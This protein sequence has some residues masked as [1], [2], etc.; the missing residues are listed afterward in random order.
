[1]K[2]A[3]PLLILFFGVFYSLN[4]MAQITVVEPGYEIINTFSLPANLTS[5]LG[6]MMFSGDG[7]M[8]Y[9][10]D[11]VESSDSALW[12]ASVVRNGS[13]D[14]TGFG[15]FSQV[16]AY[17]GM[18]TGLEFGPGT[19][20]YFFR[21]ESG[22]IGQRLTSGTVETTAVTPYDDV[23]GGLAFIPASYPNGGN[24]VT[25]SYDDGTLYL[26]AVTPD[27]DG[28]FTVNEA[29]T[30]Y[31]DF[32]ASIGTSVLGDLVF[33]SSGPLAGNVLM[34]LYSTTPNTLAYFP[35][36]ADGLPSG[37][38]TPTPEVFATG[39]NVTWGVAIDPVTDNIWAI[40]YGE[41]EGVALT[42]IGE[43]A[44]PTYTVGGSI[45]GLTGSVTLQNNGSDDLTASADGSFTFGTS[46]ADGAAYAVT[47]S[48]Q[49]IGQACNVT[50]GS[51]TIAAADVTNVGVV[52]VDDAVLPV[53]PVP[54]MSQWALILFS[55]LLGLMVFANR[56]RL[57]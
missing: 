41:P 18:D 19:G 48:T 23:F 47:V 43:T 54:T 49:P 17:A 10:L 30:L 39:D 24:M 12:S 46:L 45:S 35:L 31:A 1:M 9:I 25:T 15:T 44:A 3:Q 16:F 6:T 7:S 29:G 34:A 21:I 14:V 56:R 2:I 33:I 50:T 20:T 40:N 4:T 22:G 42:Q 55:T 37:G 28:S 38:T 53:V 8:V 13:G 27:G 26:H 52:C 57:F 11:D 36:G 32:S 5:E 51:G